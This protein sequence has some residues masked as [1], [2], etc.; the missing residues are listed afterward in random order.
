MGA[1]MRL[2]DRLIG[3]I[4]VGSSAPH[5]YTEDDLTLLG[6]VADRVALVIDR[7]RLYEAETVPGARRRTRTGP[8]TISSPCSRTSCALP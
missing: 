5:E 1:T 7:A 8:R 2:G 3:V 6:L 4:H